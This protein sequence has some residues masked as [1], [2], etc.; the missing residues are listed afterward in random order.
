MLLWTV[1]KIATIHIEL[2][3]EVCKNNQ[4]ASA[5]GRRYQGAKINQG[6]LVS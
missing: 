6:V 5:I 1:L 4:L 3:Q 2:L